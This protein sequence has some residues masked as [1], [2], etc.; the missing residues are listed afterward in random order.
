MP[1]F[2]TADNGTVRL[3]LYNELDGT[4]LPDSVIESEMHKEEAEAELIERVGALEDLSAEDRVH[5]R[6][7]HMLLTAALI[8]PTITHLLASSSDGGM[9][10]IPI[11][12]AERL[13]KARSLRERADREIKEV[14][15]TADDLDSDSPNTIREV[16]LGGARY[17]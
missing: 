1:L 6:R 11:S 3:L 13:E 4:T 17:F 10:R 16:V 9:T 12:S 2:N 14:T 5:A 7:A 15:G 8:A